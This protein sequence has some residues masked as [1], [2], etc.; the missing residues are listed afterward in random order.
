[1]S[2]KKGSQ[3]GQNALLEILTEIGLPHTLENYLSLAGIDLPL[4]N[5]MKAQVLADFPEWVEEMRRL[6]GEGRKPK[7]T[8]ADVYRQGLPSLT[9]KPEKKAKEPKKQRPSAS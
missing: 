6:H 3:T 1:M 7:K 9:L 5:E 4:D 2:H 8:L